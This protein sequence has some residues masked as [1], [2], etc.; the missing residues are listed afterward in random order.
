LAASRDAKRRPPA[1][2]TGARLLLSDPLPNCPC[3]LL[4]QQYAAPVVATPQE[5]LVPA[6]TDLKVIPP[7]T[8]VGVELSY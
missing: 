4:P 8:A 2:G 1:T 3:S 7:A 6:M 5:K